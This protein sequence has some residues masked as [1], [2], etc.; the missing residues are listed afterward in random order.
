MC[1]RRGRHCPSY[2][3]ET[4][5]RRQCVAEETK[6]EASEL[7]GAEKLLDL[8]LTEAERAQAIGNIE[9]QIDRLRLRRATALENFESPAVTFDPRLKTR[10]Y[11]AQENR[12]ELFPK[13]ISPCPS[14]EED[15]AFAS[16][17]AQQVWMTRG[18]LTSERLTEIYLRRIDEFGPRLECFVT[19]TGDLARA[20][21][22][23]ADEERAKGKVRGPLH[24]IPYVLKDLL[25]T[26]DIPTTWGA[27]P[28][29]TRV[30]TEDAAV[31]EALRE[32][33][34]VLLGKTTL[35]AIA[36][37]DIWFGG[38][39][40][41]PWN[42]QEGSSGSSAGSASATAAGLCGF[43]IGSETLGSIV[44]PSDRCGTTGLRPTFGRVS[45]HG[46][47]ALCWSFDKLGPICRR[48]EDTALVLAA[49]NG[50]DGRDAGSLDW[51][52]EY[53]GKASLAGLKVGINPKWFEAGENGRDA[54]HLL[55]ALHDLG[56]ETVEIE[57]PD[58][59]YE[60]FGTLIEV[61]S[62]A[63]FEELTLSDR[64]DELVWQT[65]QA[66]PNTWRAAQFESAVNYVQVE[67]LRRR[68]M[69]EMA[70]LFDG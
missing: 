62:A 59:P 38:M 30:A 68:L 28:Y 48:A 18:E 50:F 21:A 69:E 54:S 49:I 12:V 31:T 56:L 37:G 67:R 13:E 1:P 4:R 23:R 8:S 2:L 63:A 10:N 64:D 60:V 11:R 46:A 35:G 61:E 41:N 66:W 9:K 33:G 47:M 7:N 3:A 34:A 5:S 44:S 42:C 45:R 17:E 39:T 25:D 57:L 52:F 26:K 29:K 53:D 43:S 14:A 15:I 19:V 51:C 20:Q 40:R 6:L 58:M 27:T 22:R 65:E 16:L 36:Y 24:G 55:T 32:A 70:K